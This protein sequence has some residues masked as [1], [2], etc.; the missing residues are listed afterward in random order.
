MSITETKGDRQSPQ[1]VLHPE[2]E[3]VTVD[4]L[5][6]LPGLQSVENVGNTGR[7]VYF[8]GALT[9]VGTEDAYIYVGIDDSHHKKAQI[10]ILKGREF[11]DREEWIISDHEYTEGPFDYLLFQIY[12][13]LP[14]T[15]LVATSRRFGIGGAESWRF[16]GMPLWKIT[17]KDEGLSQEPRRLKRLGDI[18]LGVKSAPLGQDLSEFA[19]VN[20]VM[21]DA[22]KNPQSPAELPLR[23]DGTPD[24]N[25][26]P[27][28]Y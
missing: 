9:Q 10:S 5:K 23:K 24:P 17:F 20:Q 4:F 18:G 27:F 12:R 1:E 8:W 14:V 21:M 25:F 3:L 15:S 13:S 22:L 6:Q 2:A 26:F 16:K 11:Q 28:S 19:Q 7:T